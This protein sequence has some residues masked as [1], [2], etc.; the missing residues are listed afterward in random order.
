MIKPLS[1]NTKNIDEEKVIPYLNELNEAEKENNVK[2]I[3]LMG[4]YGSGKS[5]I[6]LKLKEQEPSKYININMIEFSDEVNK[7]SKN[8]SR[9]QKNTKN[10]GISEQGNFP[11]QIYTIDNDVKRKEKIEK[12]E[13]CI[14]QQLIYQESQKTI[15]FSKMKREHPTILK[16]CTNISIFLICLISVILFWG[17]DCFSYIENFDRVKASSWLSLLTFIVLI[18]SGVYLSFITIYYFY[19]NFRISKI[20]FSKSSTNFECERY[21]S[22]YNRFLDELLYFFKE[23]SYD[24]VIFEDIDRYNDLL[25]FS[26]LR[27]LNSLLNNSKYL[28]KKIRFIYAIKDDLFINQDKHK[29]FD[30]IIPVVPIMDYSNSYNKIKEF[31]ENENI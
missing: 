29:F 30:Y 14:I 15:P 11:E 28:N 1:A 20:S 6:L 10:I 18:V 22:V 8:L 9:E 13:Q 31:L 21:E 16:A 3:A 5:T 27:E 4:A 12:V 2:N 17:F 24:T 26:H 25:F 19:R 23:T 7:T